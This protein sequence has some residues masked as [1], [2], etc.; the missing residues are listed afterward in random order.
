MG[1]SETE[2]LGIRKEEGIKF[3]CFLK[4]KQ[5]KCCS[6]AATGVVFVVKLSLELSARGW[7]NARAFFRKNNPF[8]SEREEG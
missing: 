6:T 7:E 3:C 8:R 5:K 4:G 1:K 2:V